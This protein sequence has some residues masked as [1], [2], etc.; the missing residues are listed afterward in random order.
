MKNLLLAIAMFFSVTSFSQSITNT[1]PQEGDT[2]Y[3]T[4]LIASVDL[5]S[6]AYAIVVSIDAE[7]KFLKPNKAR[8]DLAVIVFNTSTFDRA[9]KNLSPGQHTLFVD[10]YSDPRTI[11]DSREITFYMQ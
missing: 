2:K 8:K 11:V 3:G 5:D 4:T 10:V 7:A 1:N 6:D 9:F